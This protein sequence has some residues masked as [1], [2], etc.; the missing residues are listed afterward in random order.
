MTVWLDRCNATVLFTGIVLL[1]ILLGLAFKPIEVISFGTIAEGINL[2]QS[3]SSVTLKTIKT[4]Q[5][6]VM[7]SYEPQKR[8]PNQ[9]YPT[10]KQ[11]L[12]QGSVFRMFLSGLERQDSYKVVVRSLSDFDVKSE[13]PK[14]DRTSAIFSVEQS[15]ILRS[16]KSFFLDSDSD[17]EY[18][19]SAGFQ[20]RKFGCQKR[21]RKF[22]FNC[23]HCRC[24]E[25]KYLTIGDR[26]MYRDD[27]FFEGSLSYLRQFSKVYSALFSWIS[28]TL[29]Q[30]T[31]IYDYSYLF[32]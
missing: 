29:S 4:I 12:M 24:H 32:S 30:L 10:L 25:K 1:C 15:M 16:S 23:W 21:C 2:V 20:N 8:L 22:C 28:P 13:A 17:E 19:S 31:I 14:S 6:S 5:D 18:V 26:P 7:V 9:A 3:S 11:A 27:V